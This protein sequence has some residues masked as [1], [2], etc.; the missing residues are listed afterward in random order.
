M[1]VSVRVHAAQESLGREEVSGGSSHPIFL[2]FLMWILVKSL[3]IVLHDM[4]TTAMI[5]LSYQDFAFWSPVFS[6][7]FP[8]SDFLW[9][10]PVTSFRHFNS[11]FC[12]HGEPLV[13]RRWGLLL[14]IWVCYLG[15]RFSIPTQTLALWH[16]LMGL[17]ES[18]QEILRQNIQIIHS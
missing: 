15:S 12:L 4:N 13:D 7:L 16:P 5:L 14:I 11:P 9:A 10:V 18:L 1:V 3:S 2:V 6:T 8:L 17:I